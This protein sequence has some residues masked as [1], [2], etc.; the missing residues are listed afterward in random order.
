MW[1]KNNMLKLL[2]EKQW[3]RYV[4]TLVAGVAIGAIFY[5]TKHVEEKVAYKYEEEIKT[6]KETH[7]Q[8]QK[9]L[10]EELTKSSSEFS[11][12]KSESEKKVEKLTTE[13]RNLQSKQKTSYYKLI[14]PDGTIEVKKFSESEVNES[15][16]TVTSI[17]EEFKTKIESIEQ[18]WE[19][20]HKT[21]LEE[22]KKQFT[23]KEETYKKQIEELQKSK[24][25]TV[26]EKRF[27][28]EAG[29]NSEKQGYIHGTG[30]LFGP[31]FM[32][33][34]GASDKEFNNKSIGLGLG[35]NF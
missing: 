13:I 35:I 4:L 17:Q 31:V 26:N 23:E 2:L 12:Y 8:E 24:V 15:S 29:M 16:K 10:K 11:F 5:P 33:V 6:L 9:S 20:I 25:T 22:V 14:K 1:G 18:K 21:R 19:S 28:A 3:V 32:G 7:A 34:H 27:G 30:T